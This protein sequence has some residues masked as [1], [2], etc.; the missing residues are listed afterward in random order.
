MTSIGLSQ[1]NQ[2][3]VIHQR[4]KGPCISL[5]TF[6]IHQLKVKTYQTSQ[7]IGDPRPIY[8]FIYPAIKDLKAALTVSWWAGCPGGESVSV[9]ACPW[10]WAST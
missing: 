5:M 8:L 7:W 10:S 4:A 6:I 1:S 9:S 2:P 3:P